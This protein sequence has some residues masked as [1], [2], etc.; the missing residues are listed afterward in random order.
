MATFYAPL[1][2]GAARRPR[3]RASIDGRLQGAAAGGPSPTWR[4]RPTAGRRPR[5]SSC[6][7]PGDVATARRRSDHPPLPGTGRER[8]RG[9]QARAGRVRRRRTCR[10]ATRRRRA[11]GGGAAPV[12]RAG[13]RAP[14]ARRDRPATGR[15][16][17]PR[18]GHARPRTPLARVRGSGR[19]STRSTAS[20]IARILSP[21]RPQRRDRVRRLP[22][23]RVHR[24][25]R[26][27]V[28][29]RQRRSP[30]TATTAGP[31]A[32][33]RKGDF[34]DLA[35]QLHKADLAAIEAAG[36]KPF[37]RAEVALPTPLPARS[38]RAG[39]RTTAG[40]LRLPADPAAG[41]TRPTPAGSP[42]VAGRGRRPDRAD[43]HA[44][45]PRRRHGAALRRHRSS[46]RT[47]RT[48]TPGGWVEQLRADPRARGAAGL[49]AWNGDR[50]AG[51][52]QRRRRRQ[53]RRPRDRRTTGSGTSRSASRRAVRCGADRVPADPARPAPDAVL[54][55][56]AR[57]VLGRL[58]TRSR[59]RCSTRRRA[60]A[61]S[62]AGPCCRPRPGGRCVRDRPAPPSRKTAPAR[63]G[64]RPGCRQRLPAARPTTR[65][66]SATAAGGPRG[67]HQGGDRSRPPAATTK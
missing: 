2:E 28:D 41:P 25:R 3:P 29:R 22:R 55:A 36:G 65:P 66:T 23:A 54:G 43:R 5:R 13:R 58:P 39:A 42:T 26:R 10:G 31:S 34:P 14:R 4:T 64:A 61:R 46:T 1:R 53:G 27:R 15:P 44:G 18:T 30:S 49:G 32:P 45:R 19:T 59:S 11:T 51:P 6:S 7:G 33:G 37:G 56:G 16:G 9:D 67:G 52:D 38:G 21:G 48:A 47:P 12:A 17:H 57:P 8:R 35:A 62:S 20:T 63:F 60:H 24:R 40:A 50:V